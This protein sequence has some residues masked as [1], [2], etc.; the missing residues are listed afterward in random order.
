MLLHFKFEQ[1][2]CSMQL[3]FDI[4]QAYA[5]TGQYTRLAMHCGERQGWKNYRSSCHSMI[6]TQFIP[7]VP[8]RFIYSRIFLFLTWLSNIKNQE[9][10]LYI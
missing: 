2:A 9:F 7:R 8:V 5:Y 3:Q 10:R 4:K 1:T 6:D